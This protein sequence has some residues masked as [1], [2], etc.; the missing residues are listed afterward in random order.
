MDIDTKSIRTGFADLNG[1]MRGKRLPAA[2]AEKIEYQGQRMPLSAVTVDLWGCD[3]ENSPL[4]FESGDADGQLRCTER[5]PLPMPWLDQPATLMPMWMF[6]DQGQPFEADPR[7]ALARVLARYARRGLKVIAA[8]EL[9]FTLVD[10]TG[11]SLATV[12]SPHTGKP[13]TD[14]AV[15]GVAALDTFQRFFDDLYAGADAMGISAQAA[16]SEAGIGQFEINLDH[17]PAMRIADDTWLFK[18]LVR[19]MARKHGMAATFMAKPFADDAG[20]GLHL[21]FSVLDEAKRNIFDNGLMT[22]SGQMLSAVAGCVAGMPG[23]TLIFAPY[24]NSYVR[25]SPGAHAPTGACWGYENR[26]AAIRIPGGEPA[27]RRIEHRTAGGDT[28]P[29]LVMAAILG[30]ALMG[31]EDELNP[32][33]PVIGNAY[34]QRILQIPTD[35][36]A[37]IERFAG[38]PKMARIFTPLLIDMYART[39]RQEKRRLAAMPPSEQVFSLLEAV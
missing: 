1:Q 7:H 11:A 3:I 29:Y 39:K 23:A 22:G 32:P 30:S 6:T 13:L 19:G 9:E 21:H 18:S 8:T 4:V 17:G 38:S 2:H 10:D 35:W 24:E 31:I 5:G 26:T 28:N 25:M 33:E 15:V 34:D 14:A 12:R 27:A 16:I 37:A 20:N 36:D